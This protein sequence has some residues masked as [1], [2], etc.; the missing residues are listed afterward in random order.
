[1][2]KVKKMRFGGEVDDTY[3]SANIANDRNIVQPLTEIAAARRWAAQQPTRVERSSPVMPPERPPERVIERMPM[4]EPEQQVQRPDNEIINPPKPQPE[5]P[6]P[7]GPLGIKTGG[8]IKKMAQGGYAKAD[9][10]AKKGKT[11]P[12]MVKMAKGGSVKTADGIAQRG[13]TKAVQFKMNKG[14]KAC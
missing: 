14:G 7:V 6:R 3:N 2:A 1:M 4:Q 12:K 9:G 11:Q 8:Q 13:K 10:V 5:P